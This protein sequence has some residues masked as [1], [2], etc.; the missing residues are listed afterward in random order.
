TPRRFEVEAPPDAANAGT[1]QWFPRRSKILYRKIIN[2]ISMAYSWLIAGGAPV[3][4]PHSRAATLLNRVK[5]PASS[6]CHK[7]ST[8]LDLSRVANKVRVG[9]GTRRRL[10]VS[11][12]SA[13]TAVDA[14]CAP[15]HLGT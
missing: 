15:Q 14:R 11:A 2:M 9:I 8:D 12:C 13:S 5:L 7:P 1:M 10:S 4:A 3:G 6:V